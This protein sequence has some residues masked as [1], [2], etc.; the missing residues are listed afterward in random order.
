MSGEN[1]KSKIKESEVVQSIDTI[2]KYLKE[3]KLRSHSF[4]GHADVFFNELQCY[5]R[6]YGEKNDKTN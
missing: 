5:M 2:K 4:K 6:L 1:N 3:H